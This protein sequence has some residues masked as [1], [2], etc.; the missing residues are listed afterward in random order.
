MIVNRELAIDEQTIHFNVNL[1]FLNLVSNGYLVTITLHRVK[2]HK[3]DGEDI[4]KLRNKIFTKKQIEL[5][6]HINS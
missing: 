1:G 3:A 6:F 5:G 4:V 2:K